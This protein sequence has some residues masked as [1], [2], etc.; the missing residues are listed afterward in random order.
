LG[1]DVA[2]V[3]VRL[4]VSVVQLMANAAVADPPAV[5][6][7]VCEVPPLTEQF[8]G[9]PPRVTVWLPVATPVKVT[10]PEAPIV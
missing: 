8:D 1:P 7:T 2:V 4:P 9:T 6:P 10:L 3:T 5:T